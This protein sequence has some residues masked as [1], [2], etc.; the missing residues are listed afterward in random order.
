MEEDELAPVEGKRREIRGCGLDERI[1]GVERGLVNIKFSC[2]GVGSEEPIG[3]QRQQTRYAAF[4]R[5]TGIV[6]EPW[7]DLGAVA[8]LRAGEGFF[9][10]EIFSGAMQPSVLPGLQ[11]KTSGS[12]SQPRGS[13]IMPSAMPSLASHLF[14]RASMKS[15]RSLSLRNLSI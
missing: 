13:D 2:G 3:S 6:E 10:A 1:G 14:I 5:N 8:V 11:A 12:K 7:V 9:M 15:L 4:R